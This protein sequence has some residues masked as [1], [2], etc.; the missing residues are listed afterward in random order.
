MGR[1][2]RLCAI[3]RTPDPS[4]LVW[5]GVCEIGRIRRESRKNERGKKETPFPS[6]PYGEWWKPHCGLS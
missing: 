2:I 4:T 6:F 3:L 1:T 5:S